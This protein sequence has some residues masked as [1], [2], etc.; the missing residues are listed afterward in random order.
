M[1]HVWSIL[2]LLRVYDYTVIHVI[3]WVELPEQKRLCPIF[4]E[5]MDPDKWD[6]TMW[7][8]VTRNPQEFHGLMGCQRDLRILGVTKIHGAAWN[9]HDEA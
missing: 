3:C 2:F 1:N 8:R 9:S 6:T 4:F 5:N 7:Y